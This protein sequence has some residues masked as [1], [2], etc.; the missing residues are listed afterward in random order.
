[1]T[2]GALREHLA[3]QD[4]EA[5]AVFCDVNCRL[6]EVGGGDPIQTFKAGSEAVTVIP[7]DRLFGYLEN[8]GGDRWEIQKV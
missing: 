1:M 3:Q 7:C 5:T 2:V 4:S 6:H 8:V